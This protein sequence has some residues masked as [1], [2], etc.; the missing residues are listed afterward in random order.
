MP[1]HTAIAATAKGEFDAIQVPTGTP[2]TGEVLLKA[3]Y[4]AMIA[5]DTYTTDLGYYVENYPTVLG[6]SA[7]GTVAKVGKGVEDLVVGDRVSVMQEIV[8]GGPC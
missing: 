5:F 6:F 1:T 3:A 8:S 4:S 7:S 2:G